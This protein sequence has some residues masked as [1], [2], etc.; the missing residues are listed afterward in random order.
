[1]GLAETLQRCIDDPDFEAEYASKRPLR[2]PQLEMITKIEEQ[3]I[4]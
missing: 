4:V 2:G 1:M 3:S